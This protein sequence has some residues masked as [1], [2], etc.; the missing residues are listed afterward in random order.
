MPPEFRNYDPA[1][2]ILSF[3]G[4]QITGFMD[5]TFVNAT[6][7]TDSFSMSVGALGDV[8][9]VRSRDR[10]GRITFTVHKES[11]INDTLSAFLQGDEASGGG[12]GTATIQDLNGTTLLEA[13]NSWLA[14]QPDWEAAVDASGIE[15]MIDC[16]TLTGVLGGALT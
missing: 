4:V 1:N 14:R 7:N 13:A 12:Y 6:R 9:R 15:W 5:G 3:R 8:T 16:E 2:V 11:P 10:T